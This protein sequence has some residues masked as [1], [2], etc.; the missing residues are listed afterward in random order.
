VQ[1]RRDVESLGGVPTKNHR[2]LGRRV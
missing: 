2:V 1:M